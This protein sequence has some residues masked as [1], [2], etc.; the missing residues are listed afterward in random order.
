[1]DL[2]RAGHWWFTIQ[3]EGFQ[4]ILWAS[5]SG[6]GEVLGASRWQSTSIRGGGVPEW[7]RRGVRGRA[8]K[9]GPQSAAQMAESA[10]KKHGPRQTRN[11]RKLIVVKTYLTVAIS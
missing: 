6:E 11:N 3:K 1:M 5:N 2:P 8:W 7:R 4:A 9:P 10:A